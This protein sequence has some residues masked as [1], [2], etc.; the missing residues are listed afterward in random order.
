MSPSVGNTRYSP[1]IVTFSFKQLLNED[2]FYERSLA[3]LYFVFHEER[4]K[5][6]FPTD[7]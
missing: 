3:K 6:M 5:D 7:A 2:I 1:L 4:A